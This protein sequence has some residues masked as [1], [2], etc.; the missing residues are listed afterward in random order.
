ME[1]KSVVEETFEELDAKLSIL[2][3]ETVDWI[4]QKML[5]HISEAYE[6]G[7]CEAYERGKCEAYQIIKKENRKK[8]LFL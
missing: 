1:K 6:R 5:Y 3:K 8:R 2:N 7:K 4:K